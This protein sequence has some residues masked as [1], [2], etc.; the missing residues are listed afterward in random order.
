M[1]QPRHQILT[2]TISLA[3]LII[4]IRLFYWQIIQG[5]KLKKQA[6]RQ[7]QKIEKNDPQRGHI[8]TSDGFPL[9]INQ[10]SYQ[11]SLYKP[12]LEISLDQVINQIDNIKLDFAINHGSLID[13]FK[14]SSQQLWLS[15]PLHFTA[16]EKDI[17]S[18]PGVSFQP[19]SSRLYPESQ[20]A[21]NI[22]GT[23]GQNQQGTQIGY[24]G[25]EAYYDKQLRGQTGFVKT[26]KNATGQ[27]IL[28][29]K[30]WRSNTHDGRHLH[31]FINRKIQFLVE[32][33]LKQ[34][35]IDYSAQ[36][37]S[38][39]VTDPANGSI[40]AMNSLSAS[41]SATKSA[42]ANFAISSL[43]EPG[44]I[45]KPLIVAMALDSQS[46]DLDYTCPQC[47]QP[48]TI[49]QYT[50]SNWDLETNPDIDLKNTLKN[51]DNISMSFI[52]DALGQEK[53]LKYFDKLNLNQ[54][55]GIDLQGEAKPL[56]KSYW[57]H[58]DLATASFG[59]GFAITQLQMIHAFNAL[60]TDG[61]TISPRIVNYFSE[62]NKII[63]TKTGQK[64]KIINTKTT[65]QIKEFLQY[66][67]ENSN[68]EKLRPKDL[69]VCGKSGTA[70][71]AKLGQY[72]ESSTIASFIGFS[73]CHQPRF[74]L[75]V[76]LVKPQ[77]SPWG[78]TTAAPIWFDLA[79]QI[80]HLL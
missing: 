76:T 50:I 33:K 51:S 37:G 29:Q 34:G 10:D 7:T 52:I 1:N 36:S 70:Q 23:L 55:T 63:N 79:S 54:K 43:F 2:R 66:T 39:I 74:S 78:S 67:V 59:Q 69:E 41:A 31:T 11:L 49:G 38:I 65:N 73:P 62:N 53:F 26:A 4:I 14:N 47:H 44:S 72:Q 35:I 3:F 71:I 8:L 19:S 22:I 5:P 6:L 12:N 24:G 42:Q 48:R 57:S 56:T 20:L 75:I 46:I 9:A 25:L 13:R 64:T 61:H 28:S 21:Q 60:A 17:L 80:T 58:I 16:K 15:F 32:Q 68:L 77:S 45:F 27:T 30:I 18:S 40:I